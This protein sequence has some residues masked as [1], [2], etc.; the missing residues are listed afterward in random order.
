MTATSGESS[1]CRI[2]AQH[3]NGSAA[4]TDEAPPC[5]FTHKVVPVATARGV[6]SD[7][8]ADRIRHARHLLLERR[9]EGRVVL[10]QRQRRR[11]VATAPQTRNPGLIRSYLSIRVVCRPA[12]Q[13]GCK[14]SSSCR[15]KG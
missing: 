6:R 13:R 14:L 9:Q 7:E 11:D 4:A 8:R 2:L 12:A 3:P 5:D 1:K 15:R 10:V